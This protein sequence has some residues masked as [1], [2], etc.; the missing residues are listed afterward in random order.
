MAADEVH[1]KRAPLPNGV[2]IH[3]WHDT[4]GTWLFLSETECSELLAE[5]LGAMINA[6]R[7]HDMGHEV[8]L[9][10][11]E[12]CPETHLRPAA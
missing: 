12:H 5:T 3:L 9:H 2:P 4:S 1:V 6:Y 8:P 7:A 11:L 10:L